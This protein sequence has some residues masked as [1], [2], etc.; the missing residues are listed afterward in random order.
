MITLLSAGWRKRLTVKTTYKT[1]NENGNS[2][3]RPVESSIF[4]FTKDIT[5]TSFVPKRNRAVVLVSSMHH[6]PDVDQ[7]SKKPEII[8]FYNS[9]KFGVDLLDQRCSNYSTGRRT[10]RWPLAIFYRL[11]DIS[12]SNSY[13]VFLSTQ[14]Q[15]SESRFSFMKRLAGQLTRPHM[16]RRER[17]TAIQ[18]DIRLS[19][20]RVLQ[21]E[22][23]TLPATG[24]SGE[25]PER[26][27][28]RKYC[29][30]CDPKKK[31]KTQYLCLLCKK[32]ICLE[33]SAMMCG[34]CRKKM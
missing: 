27:P 13:V 33:C 31:R 24:N 30:Q 34:L 19:L 10:R 8:L 17:M 22:P 7:N 32:P 6:T 4:G 5:I 3:Q 29:S 26:L 11:L 18:R 23:D 15:K 16:Q 20:R 21:L 12:A 2:H 25:P 9:T 28:I 1:R 14:L